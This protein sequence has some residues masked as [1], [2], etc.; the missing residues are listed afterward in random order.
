MKLL[1]DSLLKHQQGFAFIV[2]LGILLLVTGLAFVSFNTSDTDRKIAANNLGNAQAYYAA[3][4]AII[5]GKQELDA[6]GGWRGPFTDDTVGNATY[7]LQ[8]VDSLTVPALRD[9]LIFR[10]TGLTEGST[11]R[12]DV[13]YARRTSPNWDYAA[14]GDSAVVT[15]GNAMIDSYN[16]DSGTYASQATNGPDDRG[17]MFSENGGDI[18]SNG[19]IAL[20]GNTQVHG[21]AGAYDT[22]TTTANVDVYGTNSSSEPTTT[23]DPIQLG[24]L[25]YARSVSQAPADLALQGGAFYDPITKS[26][27]ASGNGARVTFNRSG[28]Y[29]FNNMTFTASSQLII[30]SGVNVQIYMIG[31]LNAA[32]GTVVNNTAKPENLLIYSAGTSVSVAGSATAF[33]AIYA[34]RAR[35]TISGNGDFYGATIGRV[36]DVTGGGHLHYDEG[37]RE[38]SNPPKYKKVAWQVL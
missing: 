16:S 5:R 13:T 25:L 10:S 29:F 18:G 27:S 31:T 33:A 36:V 23:L 38:I 37:L 34:P 14:F 11:S 2:V 22:V 32:G 1:Y 30:P 35:I 3:E 12:I 20:A 21:D 26:V 9:T 28:I 15:G 19:V 4:A 24:D 8:V 6:N 7:S 17:N